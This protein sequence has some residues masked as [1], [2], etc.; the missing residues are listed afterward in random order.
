MRNDIIDFITKPV[1]TEEGIIVGWDVTFRA[2]VDCEMADKL[3]WLF[4]QMDN[5]KEYLETGA[6]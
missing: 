5:T 2:T 1:Q 3:F 6:N 4:M